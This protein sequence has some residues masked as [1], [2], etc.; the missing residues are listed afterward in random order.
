MKGGSDIVA[1]LHYA[2]MSQE[3]MHSFIAERPNAVLARNFKGYSKRLTWIMDDLKSEPLIPQ[4]V[5]DGINQELN[6][7]V[8]GV[9]EIQRKIHLLNPTKREFVEIIIDRLLAGDEMNIQLEEKEQL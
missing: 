9:I 8:P 5:R 3:H 6:S 2:K 7:D 4:M 1:S